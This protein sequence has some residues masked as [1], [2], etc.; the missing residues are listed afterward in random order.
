MSLPASAVTAPPLPPPAHYGLLDTSALRMYSVAD[1]Y[2]LPLSPASEYSSESVS[3]YP[4]YSNING[5]MPADSS[6]SPPP[7][8]FQ[9]VSRGPGSTKFFLG[10]KRTD[11]CILWLPFSFRFRPSRLRCQHFYSDHTSTSYSYLPSAPSSSL[12]RYAYTDSKYYSQLPSAS[13]VNPFNSGATSSHPT[14]PGLSFPSGPQASYPAPNTHDN[15]NHLASSSS[16]GG[17]A[18]GV[19][20]YPPSS[21][22]AHA[23]LQS[24]PATA[25]PSRSVPARSSSYYPG[26]AYTPA[27]TDAVHDSYFP[28]H[29]ETP[30]HSY[31]QQDY[32]PSSRSYGA[33]PA[34]TE[35]AS[36]Y[37]EVH[38]Q[39]DTAAPVSLPNVR[40][41]LRARSPGVGPTRT[42]YARRVVDP[43]PTRDRRGSAVKSDPYSPPLSQLHSSL[44]SVE[45]PSSPEQPSSPQRSTRAKK[46]KLPVPSADK[47]F[48]CHICKSS[49]LSTPIGCGDGR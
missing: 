1:N 46:P 38:Q 8:H 45:V 4:T 19:V 17:G 3:S 49:L 23:S 30:S 13:V 22:S 11:A 48:T 28:A 10:R 5:L 24:V 42:N 27:A 35:G 44:P 43:Y 12:A 9:P 25:P 16:G 33:V 6:P 37:G 47:A 36:G 15:S 31:Q 20:A 32:P 18:A 7:A 2:I 41:M 26:D 14:T 21:S 39:H 40:E 34:T 29:G